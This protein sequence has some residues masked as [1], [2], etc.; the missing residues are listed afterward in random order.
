MIVSIFFADR[1]ELVDRQ[2]DVQFQTKLEVVEEA[3]TMSLQ[4]LEE[5]RS[6]FPPDILTR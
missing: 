2:P 6:E 5:T 3:R 4:R 1:K